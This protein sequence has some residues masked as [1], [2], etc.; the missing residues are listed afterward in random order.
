MEMRVYAIRDKKAGFFGKPDF[1]KHDAEAVR[2]ITVVSQDP[3]TL[4]NKFADDYAL[5]HLFSYD[6]VSGIVQPFAA[7]MPRF[8]VE[9]SA[10]K[11]GQQ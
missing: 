3:Q 6:D 11:G 10:L 4:V 1:F 5:Y 7:D 8:V 2:A 9:V